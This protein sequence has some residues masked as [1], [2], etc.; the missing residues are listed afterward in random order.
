MLMVACWVLYPLVLAALGAGWGVLIERAAGVRLAGALLIPTGLAGVLVVGGLLTTWRP[1]APAATFVCGAGAAIGLFIGL[2]WRRLTLAPVLAV[3]AIIAAYGAPVLLYGHPTFLGYLRLDDTAT[4]FNITDIIGTH[5]RNISDLSPST[6][7]LTYTGDVG[8]WYP[9]GAFVVPEVSRALTGIDIAWVFQPYLAFCGASIGMC[10]Y[11]LTEPLITGRR[12]RAGIAFLAAQ[13]ALLYGY[14]LWGG[15]KELT[16]AVLVVL[17]V[18]LTA[19]LAMRRP[20]RHREMLPAAVSAGALLVTLGLGAA[21]WLLPA[22]V[23]L[24]LLWIRTTR[25]A[26]TGWRGPVVSF[27]WLGVATAACAVPLW[28]TLSSFLAA[29][30]GL[31]N[32]GQDA[33]T[34]L[35]NLYHALSSFQLAGIWTVGDFRLGVPWFPTA[36]LIALVLIAA[37]AAIVTAMRRR[38]AG[39]PLYAF[40]ALGGCVIF[41]AG[42]STPWVLGKALAIS[43]PALLACGLCGTATLLAD[44]RRRRALGGVLLGL[45]ASGV[46]W[47]NALGYHDATIAPFARLRELQHIGTLLNGKGPTLI[48]DYEV[49]ADRHFLRDGA[50]TEPAELRYALLSL[51]D[52]AVLTKAAYADLDSF[53]LTTLLAY[54]SIVVRDSPVESRPP[55]VYR[56]IYSGRYYQLYQ[57]PA[58]S[59]ETILQHVPLGDQGTDPYCGNAENGAS[60]PL[61][62]IAPAAVPS[63]RIIQALGRRAQREDAQL[64]AYQRPAPFVLRGDDVQWPGDW[65]HNDAAHTLTPT[66][67]G[68]AT[69][70]ISLGSSQAFELWLGGSFSRGFSVNV[71]GHLAGRVANELFAVSGYAPVARLNLDAGAHTI[72]ITY[73]HA[74]LGPGSAENTLTSLDEIALVPLGSPDS[75]L[76]T[77][78]PRDAAYLC[79]RDLDWI[80]LVRGGAGT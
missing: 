11:G 68:S 77:V 23:A 27:G 57:R 50:P 1:T 74:G 46:I 80:E 25:R 72:T 22:A 52:G 79:G 44:R 5:A 18:G 47:S 71:D 66:S 4:W 43:S 9:R 60:L 39:M 53:P 56:L 15:V 30:G 2:P 13:P 16:S 65:I 73:P 75:E 62:S 31:F 67:P 48:N 49:Y 42:G 59:T 28:A 70:Q 32:S 51:T 78:A 55:S 14:S 61:C 12:L 6:F 34:R 10:L 33:A 76:L 58:H 37:L 54:R 26:G 45:L 35:G 20:D 17:C 8:P 38:E 64:V 63:C 7:T 21:A 36:P 29:S 40:T 19:G 3:A 24:T 69:A 41:A